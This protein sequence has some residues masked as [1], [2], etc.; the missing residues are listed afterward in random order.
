MPT[1]VD[2]T[3]VKICPR[4]PVPLGEPEDFNQA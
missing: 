4:T 1:G 3:T 2:V